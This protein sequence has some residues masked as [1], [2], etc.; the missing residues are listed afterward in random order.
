MKHRCVQHLLIYL[1]LGLSDLTSLPLFREPPPPDFD[2]ITRVL[3][4]K[5]AINH[6]RK[7]RTRC[8]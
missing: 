5:D 7:P 4:I 3:N 2:W 6:G 8:G 1:S